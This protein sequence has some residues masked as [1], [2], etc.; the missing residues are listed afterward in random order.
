M[1]KQNPRFTTPRPCILL[2]HIHHYVLRLAPV[3]QSGIHG[4]HQV[5]MA[6]TGRYRKEVLRDYAQLF[7]YH[8]RVVVNVGVYPAVPPMDGIAPQIGLGGPGCYALDGN[9][10]CRYGRR[11]GILPGA[12]QRFVRP[13]SSPKG[14]IH[15]ALI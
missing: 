6:R 10:P 7:Q 2:L 11:I 15:P 14:I 9:V 5:R 1:K 12:G 8:E 3:I 4:V 13:P